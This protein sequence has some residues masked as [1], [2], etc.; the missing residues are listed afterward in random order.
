MIYIIHFEKPY[1]H[2]RH[3]VGYCKEGLLDQRLAQHRAGTGARLM[4]AVE[5]A[6]LDWTVALTHP[7][8]RHF[9][10][11][12]KRAKNTPRFCP[13]CSPRQ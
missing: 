3:Y 2:A 6:G 10:R 13:I 7:G 5:E 4:W 8:D 9:E 1:Y 11:T 12:L